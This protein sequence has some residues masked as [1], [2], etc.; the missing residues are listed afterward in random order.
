MQV[1]VQSHLQHDM[2]A[3]GLD[4]IRSKTQLLHRESHSTQAYM[5]CL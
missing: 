4:P 3:L 5:T 2:Q 1:T